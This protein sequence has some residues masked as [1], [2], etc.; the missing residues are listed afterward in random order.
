MKGF[1]S[2]AVGIGWAY[3]A[4]VKAIVKALMLCKHFSVGQLLIESDSSLAVGWVKCRDNRPWKVINELNLIDSLIQEV[5]CLGVSH[6]LREG[7]SM[8]DFLAKAGCTRESP[9]WEWFP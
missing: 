6:I 7:N 8:A 2:K 5:G 4:E 3:E 9:L 1:F